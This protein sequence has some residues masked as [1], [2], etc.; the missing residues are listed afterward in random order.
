[1][2]PQ[3]TRREIFLAAGLSLTATATLN[4]PAAAQSN[5]GRMLT[6]T[7][8]ANVK[9]IRAFLAGWDD[10]H[11]DIDKL[12]AQYMAPNAAVRWTDDMKAVYGPTAAAAAAKAAM[13]EGSRAVIKIFSVFAHGPLV[14]TSR[15]DTIKVPGK[16]DATFDTAGVHIIK[17]GKIQEYTDYVIISNK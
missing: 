15:V 13:P 1:M 17:D 16:P 11:L 2:S 4:Q 9:L 8:K 14:A 3:I 5:T 10:P 12:V 6:A 7:E